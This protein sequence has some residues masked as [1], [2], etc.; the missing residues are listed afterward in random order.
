MKNL[1]LLSN[2]TLAGQGFLEYA[3]PWIAEHFKASPES[4][5]TILFVP[6]AL[7]Y[8]LKDYDEYVQKAEQ[9]LAPL[10]IKVIS[11][12]T[13][14]NPAALLDKV[15]G[16]FIGGGNTFELLDKLKKTGLLKAIKEKVEAGMPYMGASAGT[17]VV[18]PTLM[19]T[20]DMPDAWPES[21]EAMGLVP[22]Q[23]NPHYVDGKFYYEEDGKIVPYNGESRSDRI[24]GWHSR[25]GNILPVVA[26]KEGT[27]LRIKGKDVELLGGKSAKIF[28]KDKD[29]ITVEDGNA[30][31]VLLTRQDKSVSWP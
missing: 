30:L 8:P 31:S 17:I 15:D 16:V 22:F 5:K 11:P 1:L 2:G 19:N 4:P 28:Q 9:A 12:H 14:D 18:G 20:N 29:P 24:N 27:A 3:R 10:G 26:L 6:Y 7:P 21:P 23:I 25:S 13:S